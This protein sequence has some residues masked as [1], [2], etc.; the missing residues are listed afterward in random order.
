MLNYVKVVGVGLL[1]GEWTV[2][3]NAAEGFNTVL[4]PL[5]PVIPSTAYNYTS[6]ITY[7]QATANSVS[8]AAFPRHLASVPTTTVARRPISNP[9][10][11]RPCITA[12]AT[13]MGS[14][15]GITARAG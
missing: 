8:I 13:A 14:S 3:G 10:Q 12:A 7:T 11:V 9:K 2:W 5:F 6:P 15:A 4:A 1:T